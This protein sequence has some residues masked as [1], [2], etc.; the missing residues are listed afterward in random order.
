MS[1][2]AEKTLSGLARFMHG[3]ALFKVAVW[4]IFLM[5]FP[6]FCLYRG[7]ILGA[8]ITGALGLFIDLYLFARPWDDLP[9]RIRKIIFPPMLLLHIGVLGG[10]IFSMT[11]PISGGW[12]PVAGSDKW[13][14]VTALT[15]GENTLFLLLGSGGPKA[16]ILTTPDAGNSFDTIDYPGGFG[17]HLAFS[18]K[19]RTVYALPREGSVIWA[20]SLGDKQWTTISRPA[21]Y[22]DQMAVLND[23]IFVIVQN[24]LYVSGVQ[25]PRFTPLPEAG[26]PTHL[27]VSP[28]PENPIVLAT[29][30][31]IMES[32]DGGE[33]FKDSTPQGADFMHSECVVGAGGYRYVFSGG[34]MSSVFLTAEPGQSYRLRELPDSD[35]RVMIAN[36]IDGKEIWLGT[37]G[38]GVFRSADAGKSFH[39]MGLERNEIRA[40]WV[41]FKRRRA[42]A[43]A[44]NLALGRGLYIRE[45]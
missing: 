43:P 42:F 28:D 6:P 36:P 38:Q 29:G 34:M 3:V 26:R 2:R 33:S 5:V 31:R 23:K 45:F 27:A 12:A 40:L 39:P 22:S 8:L 14:E 37:W 10:G 30:S 24:R 18:P 13:A 4:T 19:T 32:F 1:G 41:D 16:A 17:W 44:S 35:T 20:Y 15:E 25:K 11:R 9:D 21:G 7:L